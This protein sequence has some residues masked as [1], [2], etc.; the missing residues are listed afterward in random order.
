MCAQ[1]STRDWMKNDKGSWSSLMGPT[2]PCCCLVHLDPLS[3]K[4]WTPSRPSP[5]SLPHLIYSSALVFYFKYIY[6][7]A[8]LLEIPMR[9]QRWCPASL[10]PVIG[11]ADCSKGPSFFG[12]IHWS[13]L[14]HFLFPKDLWTHSQDTVTK[15]ILT[16]LECPHLVT[17]LQ[18]LYCVFGPTI[19]HGGLVSP[20]LSI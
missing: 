1:P 14:G 12:W 16:R 19:V 15:E 10:V 20:S 13:I 3:L 4:T 11:S 8:L 18:R 9:T 5:C 17:W 6:I 2:H 7:W